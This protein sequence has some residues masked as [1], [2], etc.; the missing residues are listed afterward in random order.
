ALMMIPMIGVFGMGAE[1]SS[2]YLI[3]RAMQNTAD[4][5]AMAAATN[6]CEATAACHTTRLSATFADEA[7]SVAREFGFQND[8][9]TA[10]A[11]TKV[12]CPGG[13]KPECYQVTISRKIPV[14]L[15]R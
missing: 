2:W 7:T 11:T 3:Q 12:N 5:A 14:H 15:V 4:S 6:G 8:I 1:A 10:V 13:T 9:A